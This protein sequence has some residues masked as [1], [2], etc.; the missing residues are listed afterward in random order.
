M[1]GFEQN[2]DGSLVKEVSE[3]TFMQDVVEASKERPVIVDFWAAVKRAGNWVDVTRKDIPAGKL[4]SW[5]SYRAKDWNA[6]DRGR[7]LDHIWASADIASHTGS[8]RILRDVRSW[9]RPSDH[10]PVFAT[11]NL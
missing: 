10:V 1:L 9:E 3:A 6:A 5:W 2:T 7:R 8:S 11:I 4:Y